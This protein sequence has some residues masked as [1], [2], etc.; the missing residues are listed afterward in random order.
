[1]LQI[2]RDAKYRIERWWGEHIDRAAAAEMTPPVRIQTTP[3]CC[4]IKQS[5]SGFIIEK[6]ALEQRL[7][8]KIAI[9]LAAFHDLTGASISEVRVNMLALHSIEGPATRMV[10]NVQVVT[11]LD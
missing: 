11:P 2:I 9:E 6:R 3:S 7:R 1:M 10:A 8:T 5:M 4:D